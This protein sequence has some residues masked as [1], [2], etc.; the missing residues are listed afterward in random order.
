[1]INGYPYNSSL[2]SGTDLVLC[3]SSDQPKFKVKFY[4]QSNGLV[5]ITSKTFT[6][7]QHFEPGSDGNDWGWK[8]FIFWVP[9]AWTS[10]VYIVVFYELDN[11]GNELSNPNI[12][13]SYSKNSKALF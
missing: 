10:G 9:A 12:N 2:F 6:G 4:R 1:M 13:T 11:A 8:G 5:F 7:G 3:V